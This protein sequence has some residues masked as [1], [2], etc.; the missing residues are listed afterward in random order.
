M[1]GRDTGKH[2]RKAD[3][4]MGAPL[5]RQALTISS[6]LLWRDFAGNAALTLIA[7][8][9]QKAYNQDPKQTGYIVGTMMLF[10]MVVN[11][12]ATYYTAGKRRL[13]A[14]AFILIAGG[15]VLATIPLL[16]QVWI[17]PVLCVFQCF[18]LGAYSVGDA[19]LLERIDPAVR[20][21]F[22]GLFFT[23]VG[24]VGGT[25]PWIAGFWTDHMGDSAMRPFPYLAP[26]AVLGAMMMS[27]AG[28]IQLIKRLGRA[29]SKSLEPCCRWKWRLLSRWRLSNPYC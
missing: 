18:S 29:E 8:F 6:I 11:P 28:A 2:E 21:R 12:L 17:L 4:P 26:F 1:I 19:S 10:S 16:R 3:R 15:I 27:A 22:F 13:P 25:A 9:L 20:G 7:V 14:L 24:T 23:V 5:R